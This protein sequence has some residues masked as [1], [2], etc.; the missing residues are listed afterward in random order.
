M[1]RW[2]IV[3]LQGRKQG[4]SVT[5]LCLSLLFCVYIFG[6]IWCFFLVFYSVLGWCFR[7][8]LYFFLSCVLCALLFLGWLLSFFSVGC[9][10]FWV[11]SI[12][13]LWFSPP[14]INPADCLSSVLP[15]QDCYLPRTRSWARDVVLDWIESVADFPACWI[16]MEKT[17]TT[18][19]PAAA[20]FRQQW[21]SP[22][23]TTFQAANGHFYFDPWTVG[24][25][26]I[27]PLSN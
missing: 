19:L 8:S 22:A 9:S 24:N 3:F 27:G 23:T 15:L 21:I 4:W 12:P 7:S 5:P 11:L 2:S 1:V 17:N 13:F 14:F 6:F 20:T 10:V 25:S 16:G 18:V 26:A